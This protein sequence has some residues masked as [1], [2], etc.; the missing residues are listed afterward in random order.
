MLV[1]A[2]INS[3]LQNPVKM[4][5]TT[6]SLSS[7]SINMSAGSSSKSISEMDQN[8]VDSSNQRYGNSNFGLLKSQ[9]RTPD[10][11]FSSPLFINS[12]VD[13]QSSV[14]DDNSTPESSSAT[15]RVDVTKNR[16]RMLILE[17]RKLRN[18]VCSTFIV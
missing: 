18:E 7:K 8:R 14:N 13:L 5:G 16:R 6:P 9:L 17:C 10:P 3:F 4:Q 11:R 2:Q 12:F 15:S 1:L